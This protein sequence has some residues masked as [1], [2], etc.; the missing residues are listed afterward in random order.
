MK[1]QIITVMALCIS[2]L[3]LMAQP[4]S[5]SAPVKLL[6]CESGLMAPVWSPN[7]DQ[8]AVTTDNYT[9]ILVA[10]ADGTNLRTLTTEP[11][12]GYKMAWSQD[13]TQIMGRVNVYDNTQRV[14]RQMKKWSV[15][16]GEVIAAEGVTRKAA[17]PQWQATGT[18]YDIMVAQ[19]GEAVNLIPELNGYKGAIVINPALSPDNSTIA[20]QIPGHGV[21]L[22]NADGTNV[23]SLCK[24]SHPQWLPDGK[25]LIIT[26]VQD[27]G[28]EFT[29]SDIYYIDAATGAETLL[30]GNTDLIPLTPAV[31]PDG[32][33]IAFEN[34]ADASIYVITLNY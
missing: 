8:I 1:K 10:N 17:A 30:T 26:R 32:Q 7:G 5:A 15:A 19:A 18:A 9:G 29:A 31:S 6:E 2:T 23:R 28:A 16:N 27:N 20:F 25:S 34:A 33:R 13:G 14:N 22:C 12:A 21:M 24:G 3:G 4:K 11:G